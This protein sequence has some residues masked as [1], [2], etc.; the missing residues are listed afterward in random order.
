MHLK[1]TPLKRFLQIGIYDWD[2]QDKESGLGEA[3]QYAVILG[4]RLLSR[5]EV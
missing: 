1:L 3:I 2:T 5:L 4:N